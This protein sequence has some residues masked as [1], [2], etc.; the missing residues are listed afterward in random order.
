M[1]CH[2]TNHAR[3]NGKKPQKDAAYENIFLFFLMTSGLPGR[4]RDFRML[5]S[6]CTTES[7]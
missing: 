1:M 2:P 3:L 5:T 6:A 7:L 4:E